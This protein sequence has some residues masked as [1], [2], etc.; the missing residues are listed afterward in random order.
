MDYQKNEQFSLSEEELKEAVILY[1]ESKYKKKYVVNSEISFYC[2][3]SHDG[4]PFDFVCNVN[5]VTI[6]KDFKA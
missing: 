6:E 4:N 3:I 5:T 1:F 2:E